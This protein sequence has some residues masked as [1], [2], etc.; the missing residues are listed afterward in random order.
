MKYLENRKG[1]QFENNLLRFRKN[2]NKDF[3]I[4]KSN[5]KYVKLKNV[6]VLEKAVSSK[7]IQSLKNR[8]S[9]I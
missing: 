6:E 5:S 1:T 7:K 3:P 9:K 8:I 4:L 2:N